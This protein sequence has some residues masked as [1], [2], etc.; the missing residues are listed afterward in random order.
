MPLRIL[1]VAATDPE[2]KI[3]GDING[4]TPLETGYGFGD[5]MIIPL[6]TGIGSVATSWAMM[7]WIAKNGK[8]DLA[9]NGGIAG[10]YNEGIVKGEVVMPVSDCFA[11][12]GI[13]DVDRFLTLQEAGLLD[14]NEFP[15]REGVIHSDRF[16]TEKFRNV[17]R[18]V[19]AITVNTSTGSA[20]TVIKMVEKYNPEIETMEG[21]TFFYLCSVENI[22]F[23]ALRSIS[24]KVEP[25]N[26]NSWNISLALSSLTEKIN[27][28]LLIL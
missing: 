10:S 8:P 9:I 20:S 6:V 12:A 26:R 1:Y 13:E 15:Y 16:Y 3:L 4:I 28:V 19:R 23:L 11:D 21:A 22:P 7:A 24:N 5:H 25:R 14:K 17:I 27:E 2:T 18:P